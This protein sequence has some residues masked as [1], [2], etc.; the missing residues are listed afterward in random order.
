META[1]GRALNHFN[2]QAKGEL[3]RA[4]AESGAEASSRAELLAWAG[5]KGIALRPRDEHDLVLLV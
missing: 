5:A 4:L 1:A 3:V 2:K